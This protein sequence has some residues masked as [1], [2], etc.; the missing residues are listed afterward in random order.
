MELLGSRLGHNIDLCAGPFAELCGLVVGLDLELFDRLDR[1]DEVGDVDAG[2][3]GVNAVEGH[4]LV[5]L[6]L[7]DYFW[8]LNMDLEDDSDNDGKPD[9]LLTV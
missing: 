9:E 1:G 6:A 4:S 2:I 5:N 8:D 7:A 3:F